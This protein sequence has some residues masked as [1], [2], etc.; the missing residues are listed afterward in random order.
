MHAL[1]HALRNLW[2]GG[3]QWQGE[4]EGKYC[5]EHISEGTQAGS[6]NSKRGRSVSPTGSSSSQGSKPDRWKL[7]PIEKIYDCRYVPHSLPIL[8]LASN[9][10]VIG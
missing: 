6:V 7:L 3:A 9:S 5:D 8:L 1:H 4:Q 2:Q 10:H